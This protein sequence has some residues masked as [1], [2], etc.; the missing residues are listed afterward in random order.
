MAPR[1]ATVLFAALLIAG[2]AAA[3]GPSERKRAIDERID[4]IQERIAEANR[5]QGVLTSEI[6][7]VTGR[8]R[9]LEGDID[10]ASARLVTIEAE[11][12]VYRARL[13]RLTELYRTQTRKLILLRRQHAVAELRLNLRLVQIYQ[14]EQASA[15]EVVLGASSLSDV[16]SGLDYLN[17]IGE[18]DH[19]I[20]IQVADSRQRMRIARERTRRTRRRVAATTKVIA[21]RAAEQRAERDRLLVSQRQ[22]AAARSDKQR[23]LAAVQTDERELRH[24]MEG[25]EQA[26]RALAARIQSLQSSAPPVASP[27]PGAV[28]SAGMIWPVNGPV[29]SGFGWRW[30]RMHEGIDIAAGS[31]TPVMAAAS[32]RV[33]YASWMSGYGNLVVVDHGGGLA[34]AYA[35]LSGYAVGVGSA[36][37]QGQTVGYVGCTGH[38]FGDH[39]HFEV[40]VNGSAVDPL[41]YL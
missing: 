10:R 19:D 25:L 34:T 22:L 29:T 5:K 12:A 32:G 9:V 3:H 2:S 41:G 6:S 15:V 23:T 38:C 7:R 17:Q 13:A 4:Q 39:L 16:V 11:L 30:G 18:A 21:A 24:E 1:L 8:I 40:R 31:G 36:V 37:A 14:S 26:S 35:H 33:I 28:S 20:A 27:S